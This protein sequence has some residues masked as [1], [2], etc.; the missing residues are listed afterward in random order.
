LF[1]RIRVIRCLVCYTTRCLVRRD[2]FN[3]PPAFPTPEGSAPHPCPDRI[4]LHIITSANTHICMQPVPTE[5]DHIIIMPLVAFQDKSAV[6]LH[7][8]HNRMEPDGSFFDL[9]D[10]LITATKIYEH[11]FIMDMR[12][13]IGNRPQ[14]EVIKEISRVYDPWVDL[15]IRFADDVIDVVVADAER[16]V[17]S[18]RSLSHIDELADSLVLSEKVIPCIDVADGKLVTHLKVS[19]TPEEALRFVADEGFEDVILLDNSLIDAREGFNGSANEDLVRKAV[20][21]NLGVYYGGGLKDA[22]TRRLEDLGAAGALLYMADILGRMHQ[23]SRGEG[24]EPETVRA[25]SEAPSP[26]AA[27]TS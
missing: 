4:H 15:G 14:L 11:P 6:G 5:D 25:E 20:D 18:L 8:I 19:D 1:I 16:V 3:T 22:D 13:L 17:V 27:P 10:T 21:M 23:H 9:S 7:W 2:K 24:P 12:G 26:Y